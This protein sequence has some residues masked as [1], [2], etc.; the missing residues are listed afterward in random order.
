MPFA[1]GRQRVGHGVVL[2]DPLRRGQ[3]SDRY[4]ADLVVALELVD[5]HALAAG[6]HDYLVVHASGGDT[7]FLTSPRHYRGRWSQTSLEDLVPSDHLLAVLVYDLLHALHEI[8][9]QFLL[10]RMLLVAFQAF[11]ADTGLAKRAFLPARL[12]ALIAS[13]MEILARE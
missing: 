2:V 6:G 7:A 8:A 3:S 4:R 9:L 12:R 1:G 13:D 10:G 11:L 5:I